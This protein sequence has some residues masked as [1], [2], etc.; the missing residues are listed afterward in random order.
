MRQSV[1]S[2]CIP[3]LLCLALGLGYAVFAKGGAATPDWNLAL[4]VLG[5][6]VTLFGLCHPRAR[7]CPPRMTRWLTIPLLLLLIIPILQLIPVPPSLIQLLSP[8]RSR[9]VA[10]LAGIAAIHAAPLSVLPAATVDYLFRLLAYVA[11]L[12][13][14]RATLWY[15]SGRPWMV[16]APLLV[17]GGFEALLGLVQVALD[18]PNG[19]ARGTY[20]NRDHFAGLLEMIL[21]FAVMYAAAIWR[22]LDRRRQS[23]A[24]PAA[25]A[26]ALTILAG[27]LLLAVMY[28]LS[29]MGF[30]VV[31]VSL[32]VVA[33]VAIVPNLTSKRL[34]LGLIL[35]ISIGTALAFVFLQTDQMIDRFAEMLSSDNVSAEARLHFWRES[36]SLIRAYPVTGCGLGAFEPAFRRFQATLP[37]NTIDYAHNDYLQFLAELGTAGFALLAIVAGVIVLRTARLMLRATDINERCIAIACFVSMLAMLLHSAVDFNMQMPANALTMAWIAGISLGLKLP[38]YRPG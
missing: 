30:L 16:A 34:R 32:L 9:Q 19:A 2:T 28:S 24:L 26:G 11:A 35:A 12:L 10:S 8:E 37:L 36:V 31:L 20:V 15:S 17:I 25:A 5:L 3:V 14:I 33:I 13:V 27:I 7:N 38:S 22:R 6:G 29:R 1:R 21:P 4:L 18:W 23:P